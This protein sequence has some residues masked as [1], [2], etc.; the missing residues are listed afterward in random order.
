MVHPDW[1]AKAL[2]IKHDTAKQ[3]SLTS[4]FKGSTGSKSKQGESESEEKKEVDMEDAF[5][6][7][8]DPGSTLHMKKRAK[9][10]LIKPPRPTAGTG[11]AVS[12]DSLGDEGQD[13]ESGWGEGEF[14]EREDDDD[15]AEE[16][17]DMLGGESG[18]PEGSDVEEVEEKGK[19]TRRQKKTSGFLID[20]DIFAQDDDGSDDGSVGGKGSAKKTAKGKGKGGK[21]GKNQG[22]EMDS[23]G[24]HQSLINQPMPDIRNEFKAWL[25]WQQAMWREERNKRAAQRRALYGQAMP[26]SGAS[27]GRS[28][29][30]GAGSSSGGGSGTEVSLRGF[31]GDESRVSTHW[32]IIRI[33][34]IARSHGIF[35]VWVLVGGVLRLVTLEVPRIIYLNTLTKNAVGEAM[36]KPVE[37]VLPRGRPCLNLYQLTLAEEEYVAR[38]NE[39]LDLVNLPAV[40]G[41]YE[42]HVPLL[43]NAIVRSGCVCL[44]QRRPGRGRFPLL[45][46]PFPALYVF[47]YHL[48]SSLY[49][50]SFSL[51]LTLPLS[52][53]P[54]YYPF[55]L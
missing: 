3:T 2:R 24:N 37:R 38:R 39:F 22:D 16:V 17:N 20:S 6:M 49:L 25:A 29:K 36:G 27:G 9:V 30:R 47:V 31:M 40:E 28:G 35:D 42:A 55:Y 21:G 34:P 52:I 10:L 18:R 33:E 43:F 45:K 11:T 44:P 48:F 4:F 14:L 5:A 32:Q 13:G 26:A 50:M 19:S 23:F 46:Y 41:L 54:P 53:W 12:G 1:L 8:K 51:L 7:P 15:D